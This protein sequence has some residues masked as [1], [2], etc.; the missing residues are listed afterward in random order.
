M[1]IPTAAEIEAIRERRGKISG[2]TPWMQG[3]IHN[4]DRVFAANGRSICS[5]MMLDGDDEIHSFIANAP[6]DIATLLAALDA[7]NQETGEDIDELL[8][9]KPHRHR[10]RH[11]RNVVITA[12]RGNTVEVKKRGLYMCIDCDQ[13]KH[14]KVPVNS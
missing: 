14:G 7:A 3:P 11:I 8:P 6:T 9:E 4:A 12:K 13:R 1:T 10:W 5:G 2:P